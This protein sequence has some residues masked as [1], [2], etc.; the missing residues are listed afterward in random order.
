M[1]IWRRRGDL[2]ANLNAAAGHVRVEFGYTDRLIGAVP[3][4]AR[5][6]LTDLRNFRGGRSLEE[7]Y[8]E[9]LAAIVFALVMK[10]GGA[11]P[12]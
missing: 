1:R 9:P 11:F 10:F 2:G 7:I 3:E 6:R 12:A 8:C 4:Q 5:G